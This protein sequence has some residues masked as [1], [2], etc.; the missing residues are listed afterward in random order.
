MSPLFP[1]PHFTST[2]TKQS[3]S[4][5]AQPCTHEASL[6][7]VVMIDLKLCLRRAW[8]RCWLGARGKQ[9]NGGEQANQLFG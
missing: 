6:R 7:S 5:S 4:I 2:T 9:K 8:R 3:L 1:S